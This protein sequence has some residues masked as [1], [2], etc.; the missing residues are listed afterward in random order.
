MTRVVTVGHST[1][2]VDELVQILRSYDVTVLAD[3]RTV[4]RSRH[5]PQFNTDVLPDQL[6]PHGIQYVHLPGLGGLRK[7]RPDSPN[8]GW[9]NATFRGFADYMQTDDFERALDEFVALASAS[10][11]A[12]MCAEALP[13]RCHRSMVADALTVRGVEVDHATAPDRAEPHRLTAFARVEGT[14]ITYP[15]HTLF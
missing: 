8:A 7:P 4:P 6:A 2:S 5:N 10:P 14:S 12:I 15:G 1:R 9:R 3:V 13:W 11:V